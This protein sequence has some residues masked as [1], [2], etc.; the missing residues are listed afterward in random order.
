MTRKIELTRQLILK[1]AYALFWRQGFARAGVDEIAEAAGITKRTLYYHFRSKDDLL[2]AVLETQHDLAL[3]TWRTLMNRVSGSAGSVVDGIFDELAA[4]SAKPDYAGAGF[5]RFVYELADLPG[6]PAR[7]IARRHK[8]ELI[9][10]LANVLAGRGVDAAPERAREMW[11]IIEGTMMMMP[12]DRDRRY[13]EA[14]AA[15]AHRLL[16]QT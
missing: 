10:S 3:E 14:A 4:W 12:V 6:R 9:S 13:A 5:S 11:L 1:S 8:Q 15:A 2:A 16:R 7:L